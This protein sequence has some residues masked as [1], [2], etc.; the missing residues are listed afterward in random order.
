[1]NFDIKVDLKNTVGELLKLSKPGCFSESVKADTSSIEN[2]NG[3]SALCKKESI[4]TNKDM[5]LTAAILIEM[6]IKENVPEEY[7]D[8]SKCFT[9]LVKSNKKLDIS[10]N[11]DYVFFAY[12]C[13]REIEKLENKVFCSV[14]PENNGIYAIASQDDNISCVV[15]VNNSDIDSFVNVDIQGLPGRQTS[16]D[17]YFAD[18]YNQLSI[19]CNTDT[20]LETT[21]I[22]IP[23]SP[24]SLH[25]FKIR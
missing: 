2:F 10:E 8:C 14:S 12:E 9:E 7:V 24:Y 17:Y 21:K 18:E 22:M 13:M 15:I 16:I 1:M 25:M 4:H 19:A 6:Q 20:K 3:F 5:S 11:R 23:V